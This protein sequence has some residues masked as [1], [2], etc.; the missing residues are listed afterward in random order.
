MIEADRQM[1]EEILRLEKDN[2]RM[3]HS[4]RRTAF[5]GGVFKLILWAGLIAAPIW[6]YATYLAPIVQSVQQTVNQV[7]NTGTNAQAQVNG[8][9]DALQQFETKFM[10]MF[11][12]K[13]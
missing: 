6:L 3:L 5:W 8:F 9:G 10:S 12:G 4:M 2:N 1:Q 7:Q 13:K 11:Q